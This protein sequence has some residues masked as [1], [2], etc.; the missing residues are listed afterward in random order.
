MFGE[1]IRILRKEKGYSQEQLARKNHVTQS[2]ISQ[3]EKNITSP[4]AEQLR[5]LAQIFETTV[6]DI[7]GN[8]KP[9]DRNKPKIV[10]PRTE[11][12]RILAQGVDRMPE[13]DRKRAIEIMTMVFNQYKDFFEKGEDDATRL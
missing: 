9:E 13:A 11:E 3:W 5:S 4:S 7:I 8:A 6:D 12:A 2:A 1:R 10:Q